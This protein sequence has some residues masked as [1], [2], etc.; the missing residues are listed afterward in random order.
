MPAINKNV[1][2]VHEISDIFCYCSPLIAKT[3]NG[4][5][6]MQFICSVEKVPYEFSTSLL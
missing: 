2:F 5:S 6:F 4:Y 3:V 1:I